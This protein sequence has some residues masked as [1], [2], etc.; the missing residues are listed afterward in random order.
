MTKQ[1]NTFQSTFERLLR[2]APNA[3]RNAPLFLLTAA[4]ALAM[5]VFAAGGI[6]AENHSVVSIGAVSV[7]LAYA[8][9]IMSASMTLVSLVLAG[10]AAAQKADPREDQQKRAGW[11][12]TIAIAVLLAPIFYAGSCV[13]LNTQR[14]EW[15]AYHGSDAERADQAL[16]H[17]AGADSIVRQNA[18][19]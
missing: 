4:V 9:A 2:K 1:T 19:E 7:S 3:L 14:A 11:T 12:Q 16:A 8:E 5:E 15:L 6:F 13:A 10:A 17:D 18:A